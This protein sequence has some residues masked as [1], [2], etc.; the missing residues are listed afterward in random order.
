MRMILVIGLIVASAEL[1][2][3]FFPNGSNLAAQAADGQRTHL[4]VGRPEVS[5]Q[6]SKGDIGP[7]S[8][9]LQGMTLTIGDI[10]VTADDAILTASNGNLELSLGA[11][12]RLAIP[13]K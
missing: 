2:T 5:M 6:V 7:N 12:A 10:V 1:A 4:V 8:T 9:Q 13:R 11:N 3:R